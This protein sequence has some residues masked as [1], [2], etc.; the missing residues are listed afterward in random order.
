[1]RYYIIVGIWI[2]SGDTAFLQYEREVRIFQD[3]R[4]LQMDA[5]T[6][7]QHQ[8]YIRIRFGKRQKEKVERLEEMEMEQIKQLLELIIQ[9]GRGIEQG[10]FY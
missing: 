8:Q 9:E 1:M 2:I 7:L 6:Y 3:L 5:D 4:P 10:E